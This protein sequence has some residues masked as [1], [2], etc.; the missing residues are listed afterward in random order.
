MQKVDE[1]K[2]M[3]ILESLL[4]FSVTSSIEK[5]SELYA[6][7]QSFQSKFKSL[8]RSPDV[9]RLMMQAEFNFHTMID[10]TNIKDDMQ[11][12]KD[13]LQSE[14]SDSTFLVV[15]YGN[16]EKWLLK[17][18]SEAETGKTVVCL[19]PARTSTA[20]FHD[21]CL[22]RGNQIRFVKGKVTMNQNRPSVNPDAIVVYSSIPIKKRKKN[23]NGVAILECST[24]L[25]STDT[26]FSTN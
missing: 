23:D 22:N 1:K 3:H 6:D 9:I 7:I 18:I 25:A 21:L 16:V 19:I 10:L 12:K 20:W 2:S 11:K 14:W 15:D 26:I 8:T 24:G 5:G 17:A 4:N 13:I